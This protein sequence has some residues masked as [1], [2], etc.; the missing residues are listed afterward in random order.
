MTFNHTLKLLSLLFGAALLSGC[1]GSGDSASPP[2]NTKVIFS[3]SNNTQTDFSAVQIH[4]GLGGDVVFEGALDCAVNQRNCM[5]YYTGPEFLTTA[6]LAFKNT[7]GKTI[8]YYDTA[9]APG[10]YVPAKVTRWSTGVYLAEALDHFSSEIKA[11]SPTDFGFRWETFSQNYPVSASSNDSYEQLA[12]YY[13][14][15]QLLDAPSVPVFSA[16]LAQRLINMEVADAS[17]FEVENLPTMTSILLGSGSGGCPPGIGSLISIASQMLGEAYFSKIYKPISKEIGKV[18]ADACK[19]DGSSA[20]LD[21]IINALN[22]LQNAVDNLQN[23]LGKL[24]NF[25]ATA[26]MDTNV[27]SFEDVTTDL[28]QLSKNYE[29]IRSN[30]KVAS[31]KEY[32]AKRGGTGKDA[33]RITLEKDGVG[34]VFENLISRISSTSNQNYLLQIAGLTGNKFNTLIRALDMLC[35]TPSTGDLIQLRAQCNIVIGTTL[36]RMVSMQAMAQI[37]AG[38]TYDLF[39]AYPSEAT[40]FG[41]DLGKTAAEHKAALA[42]KFYDQAEAMA[43]AYKS[44]VV[45]T[46]GSKGYYNLFNGLSATLLNSMRPEDCYDTVA[47]V[48]KITAWIKE[49]ANEYLITNCLNTNPLAQWYN[50]GTGRF[51]VQARYYIK[52]N[53]SIVTGSDESANILGVLVPRRLTVKDHYRTNQDA[54]LDAQP[55]YLLGAVSMIAFRQSDR[56]VAGTFDN[57]RLHTD[58]SSYLRLVASPWNNDVLAAKMGASVGLSLYD[59]YQASPFSDLSINRSDNYRYTGAD[60]FSYVFLNAD[61]GSKSRLVCL[62]G[63]CAGDKSG[64][65]SWKNGPQKFGARDA[66]RGSSRKLFGWTID[67]KFIDAKIGSQ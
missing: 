6:V 23:D 44:G 20:K 21:Q 38:E 31:L 52:V 7:Q 50:L 12:A 27:Q 32:V 17:Q 62:S 67:G 37:L 1:G 18:G 56:P 25:I 19:S 45:N 22:N 39:E 36:S 46:D 9:S 49:A 60:G 42:N 11:M 63:E 13:E 64:G 65:L 54:L 43:N 34:S 59:H 26:Q 35:N 41:Y 40:R 4:N 10:N 16:A 8:A 2:P 51:P 33:L 55:W 28:L 3:V 15:Q 57:D 48:P 58:N 24:T 53:G 47:D 30:E 61:I 5:V 29:V 66:D 14:S